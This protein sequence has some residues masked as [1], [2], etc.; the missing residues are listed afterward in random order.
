MRLPDGKR[1]IDSLVSPSMAV[2]LWQSNSVEKVLMTSKKSRKHLGKS[3]KKSR[4]LPGLS[5]KRRAQSAADLQKLFYLA[6]I[7]DSTGEAIISQNL[8]GII[9]TWNAGAQHLFGYTEAEAVG[10]P[11]FSIMPEALQSSREDIFEK[12]RSGQ[13]IAHFE[14]KRVRKDGVPIDVLLAISPIKNAEGELMGASAIAYDITER[15][16]IEAQRTEMIAQ[17]NET[18]SK[19]R[20]LSGLLPICAS[21][22]KI[23]DDKGYWQK[24]ETFVHEHSNA[25]FSHSICPDCMDKL[26]PDF[27]AND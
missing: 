4:A 10:R 1:V 19:V 26:Y 9:T 6:A 13:S 25:E 12:L 8:E 27:K 22:K 23:R 24:L 5:A 15:K 17:L 14:T 20:T 11:I 16:K 18:L 21:C 3:G 2:K 7:V